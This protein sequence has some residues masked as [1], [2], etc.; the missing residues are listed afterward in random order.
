MDCISHNLFC[1]FFFFS[2]SPCI[3]T[4][5]TLAFDYGQ[6][7]VATVFNRKVML[8]NCVKWVIFVLVAFQR[9]VLSILKIC[10][11]RCVRCFYARAGYFCFNDFAWFIIWAVMHTAHI[12]VFISQ[13]GKN[14]IQNGIK[15]LRTATIRHTRHSFGC[16]QKPNNQITTK[17]LKCSKW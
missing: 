9:W 10:I 16:M 6:K 4:V 5:N 17:W 14:H 15:V 3:S 12:G 11:K 7:H 1:S 13:S 2:I 8:S